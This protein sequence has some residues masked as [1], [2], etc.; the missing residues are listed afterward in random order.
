MGQAIGEILPVAKTILDRIESWMARNDAV[1]MAV[2]CLVI[3]AKLRG[4]AVRGFAA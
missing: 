4:Q 1:I 2:P 3:G